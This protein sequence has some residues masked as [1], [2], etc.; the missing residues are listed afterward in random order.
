MLLHRPSDTHQIRCHH[1]GDKTAEASEVFRKAYALDNGESDSIRENLR[2]A[3]EKL[4]ERVYDDAISHNYKLVRR[5]DS[6]YLVE[7]FP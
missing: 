1:L 5:S 6:D 2:L 4:N 7:Q 3:L